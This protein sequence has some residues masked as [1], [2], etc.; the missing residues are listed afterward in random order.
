MDHI[1]L[2][3]G[4]R[5]DWKWGHVDLRVKLSFSLIGG[6]HFNGLFHC[7]MITINNNVLLCFAVA[8]RIDFS[9]FARNNKFVRSWIC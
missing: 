5:K 9:A 8:K 2:N 3:T 1:I 4:G 7:L 6:I